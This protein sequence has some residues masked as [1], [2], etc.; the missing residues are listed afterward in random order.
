MYAV[1]KL[2]DYEGEIF[3][4]ILSEICPKTCYRDISF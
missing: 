4:G 3:V 1:V 2:L